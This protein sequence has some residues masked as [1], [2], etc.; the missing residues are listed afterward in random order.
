MK[1]KKYRTHNCGELRI[2]DVNK[3]VILCGWVA[4]V[5]DLGGLLFLSLRDQFGKTQLVTDSTSILADKIR[6]LAVETVVRINGIVHNRPDEM[7]NKSMLT[8]EIEISVDEMEILNISNPLPLGVEDKEDAGEEL[9]LKYRYLDLRRQR[10]VSN[11]KL[12]HSALQS[13]RKFNTERGLLEVE[14]PVLIKST[15]EGARDYVVPSRISKGKF[16]AL[17]QSPQLY[18]QSLII[19]GVDRY[20]QIARCFRDEDMRADRQ[21]EFS[22]IDIE[23]AFVQEED[24]WEHIED[25]VVRLVKD[26][27]ERDINKPFVRIDYKNAMEQYGSDAPD[28]RFNMLL[29]DVTRFFKN[30]GFKAFDGIVESGGA[31]IGICGVGKGT[32]SRKQKAELEDLGRSEGLAGLLNSPVTSDGAS[33]ILGKIFDSNNQAKLCAEMSA[34]EGDLLMFAAGT[35]EKIIDSLGTVRK[36]LGKRW[37]LYEKSNL[38]FCWVTNAPLFEKTPDGQHITAVHHPFTAPVEEDWNI[39]TSDPL[40]VRSRAYDLVLNG[41]ELGSGSIR[42]HQEQVQNRVFEAIGMDAEESK[43]RFGF[44]LEALTYGAPPHGGIAIGLDRLVMLLAGETSI[45]DVIAFPK[46]NTAISPMDGSPSPIDG[47]QLAGLGLLLKDT[48]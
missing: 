36:I 30:S 42:N 21:P 7:V 27:N 8:G 16:Y 44:L 23:M 35:K 17:P 29:T 10:M 20:F 5:R 46:T 40:S 11:L 6:Q 4:R 48:K 37:E 28:M 13:I 19:G 3:N 43:K 1:I 9:R 38:E 41:V 25:M 15:P 18:K 24:I 32:L 45:R 47:E 12:R 2:S 39:L 14:T 22:Q 34:N 33:G 31:V 26:V